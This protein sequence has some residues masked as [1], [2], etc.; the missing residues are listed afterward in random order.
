MIDN[1]RIK[2]GDVIVVVSPFGQPPTR[3][4]TTAVRGATD[5]PCSPRRFCPPSGREVSE[6]F[7]PSPDD[8]FYSGSM[9]PTDAIAGLGLVAGK[10]VLSPTR[11]TPRGQGHTGR[12]ESSHLWHGTLPGGAQ[13][14]VMH[15][16]RIRRGQ[17]TTPSRTSSLRADSES[18]TEWSEMYKV[19]NM[20]HRLEVYC[21]K[22][23]SHA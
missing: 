12:N 19:F 6:S 20:G 7:D 13:T 22:R 3:S 9:K 17:G 21:P 10:L 8:L 16:S 11:T 4:S 18:Q 1:A 2:A 23:M 14:K 5:R 15:S